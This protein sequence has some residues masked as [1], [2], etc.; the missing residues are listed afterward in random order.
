MFAD[1]ALEWGIN[2]CAAIHMK[3]GK[4]APNDSASEMPV[5]NDCSIPVIGSEDHYKLLGKYQ[6]TQH[7]EDKVI[8]EASN[9]YENRL[10]AVWTSPLSI[11][12]KVRATN[13]YAIPVLQYY[14]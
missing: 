7:L 8:E 4:L 2:K 11:P 14:M 10:W 12:R 1:I 13:V 6:N 3:R 9:Q 5:S